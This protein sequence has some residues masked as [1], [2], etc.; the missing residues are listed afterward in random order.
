MKTTITTTDHGHVN[1][2]FD[3]MDGRRRSMQISCP[4]TGGYVYEI[5]PDGSTT[6][7]CEKLA[8]SGSTLTAKSRADLPDLVRREYRRM[9]RAEKREMENL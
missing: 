2:E 6:Q 1:I 3:T 9:R 7:V 4:T 8:G 5:R